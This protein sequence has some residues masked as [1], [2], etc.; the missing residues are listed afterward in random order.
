MN[1]YQYGLHLGPIYFRFYGL[2]IVTGIFFAMILSFKR[3]KWKKMDSEKLWDMMTWLVIG[4]VIGARLWHIF[5][6]P[7]SMIDAGITTQFYLTH[8]LDAIA[9]WKGGLGIPG[10]IIMGT[11][12]LFLFCRKHQQDFL[13]WADVIA[14]ALPMAQAIGRWGNFINQELYGKPSQLPWAIYIEPLHRLTEFSGFSTY[15]P[16]FLYECFWNLAI[17]V[18]LLLIDRKHHQILLKGDLLSLY[19]M[20]YSFGR[21][22]LEFLRLD[23]SPVAGLNINQ[24]IMGITFIIAL[25]VFLVRHKIKSR[26]EVL[27]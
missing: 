20:G 1:I 24:T 8:P 21:F 14:P 7:Q 10:A 4:G 18:V 19:L 13:Q 9:I 26:P 5:T 27:T 6:P 25:G 11:I 3:A 2:L 23:P 17:A 22:W 16:L 15:H 12:A